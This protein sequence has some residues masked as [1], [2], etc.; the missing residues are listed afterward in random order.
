MKPKDSCDEVVVSL[1][2]EV[3]VPQICLL[4]K[5]FMWNFS[6]YV[7]SLVILIYVV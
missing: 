4:L 6:V 1:S 5:E 7:H 3:A 2:E